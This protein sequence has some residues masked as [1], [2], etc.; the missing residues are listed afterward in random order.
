MERSDAR[1]GLILVTPL[2]VLLVLLVYYP[3]GLGFDLSLRSVIFGS[4]IT[5]RYVGL[6][7]YSSV[8]SN[9]DTRSAALH[10]LV[11]V[12]LADG[13]E[14]ALGLS[15]A[16]ALNKPFRGRGL[17][18]AML[19]VPWALPSV[20][21]SVL[22]SRIL[23]PDYGVL[24]RVLL[25]LHLI[26]KPVLWMAQSSTAIPAITLVHAWGVVPLTTLIVLAGLQSIR[27]E[28]YEAA[29]ADG[30]SALG[31]FR[32]ITLPLLRPSFAVALVT[33]TTAAMGI[34]DEIFVLNGTS[35]STRSVMMQIYQTTFQDLDFG[36][37]T[38]LAFLLTTATA[39]IGIAYILRLR[40][41]EQ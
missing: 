14:L 41:V 3:L 28:L 1:L 30:A 6:R 34:F 24:D 23:S 27:G 21:S 22:W 26:D 31:A 2:V 40:R 38:A 32:Q 13:V 18:L 37:G 36:R 10:T 39:L 35:L 5:D 12:A 29:A 25:G 15:F 17:V 9:P 7:N 33:G 19:I 4:G 16:L 11:Y 20:V 8:L